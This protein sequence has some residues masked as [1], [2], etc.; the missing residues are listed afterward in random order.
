MRLLS[1]VF[2]AL[3][4]RLYQVEG[5]GGGGGFT[6]GGG[7]GFFGPP[8]EPEPEPEPPPPVPGG[9]GWEWAENRQVADIDRTSRFAHTEYRAALEGIHQQAQAAG[10][11]APA[12]AQDYELPDTAFGERI[13]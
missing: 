2:D 6:G 5:E 3:D 11:E 12:L 7:G 8:P 1:W 10:P 9:P 4:F 13:Y